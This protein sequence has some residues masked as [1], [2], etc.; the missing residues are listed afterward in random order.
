MAKPGRSFTVI[1]VPHSGARTIELRFSV[2]GFRILVALASILL[3][4]GII[5]VALAA[6]I[7]IHAAEYRSL[8]RRIAELEQRRSQLDSLK[9]EL[10]RISQ[11]NTRIQEMLGFDQ[12]P[13]PIE[14]ERLY[15]SLGVTLAPGLDEDLDLTNLPQ[16]SNPLVPSLTPLDTFEISRG[17]G[18]GHP[19]TDLVAPSGSRVRASADGVV[20]FAGW[21][22]VYGNSIRIQHQAG[23][24]TFYG[25][26]LRILRLR[27]DSVRQ[28]QVIGY[29]GSTGRST[30]PHLHYEVRK[31]RR[32]LDPTAFFR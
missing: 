29:L 10:D 24:S 5:L 4:A 16:G 12:Q 31:Y 6:R 23:Y 13:R 26:L 3:L 17:Q 22:T 9:A 8:Q 15:E 20:T 28:G 7:H 2:N 19:G 14:L 18:K 11:E 27:G 21:D 32:V 30:A 25:H 1:I